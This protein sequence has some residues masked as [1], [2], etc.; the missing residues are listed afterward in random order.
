MFI[1]CYKQPMDYDLS[2]QFVCTT[3]FLTKKL[4]NPL[5]ITFS[6]K[7]SLPVH[8]Y[9]I[10]CSSLMNLALCCNRIT[11]TNLVLYVYFKLC[12]YSFSIFFSRLLVIL[13]QLFSY[14][15][16]LCFLSSNQFFPLNKLNLLLLHELCNVYQ[17]Q[18]GCGVFSQ[19]QEICASGNCSIL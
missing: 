6:S 8:S 3:L 14:F 18:G 4:I 12:V 5:Y 1:T 19:G 13:E 2:L 7:K 9:R 10:Q 17:G 15:S 11:E 16:I